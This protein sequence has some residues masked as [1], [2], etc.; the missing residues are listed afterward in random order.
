MIKKKDHNI[1]GMVKSIFEKDHRIKKL[2]KEV[3]I[4][5]IQIHESFKKVH[6]AKEIVVN[7]TQP[8]VEEDD[9]ELLFADPI[10]KS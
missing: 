7:L 9:S 8:K 2:A 10:K 3:G 5:R 6:K 4:D 1:L